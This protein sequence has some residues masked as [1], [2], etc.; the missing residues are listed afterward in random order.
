MTGAMRNLVDRSNNS[1]LL[2]NAK[3]T[4]QMMSE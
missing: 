2:L 4:K 3:E 1:N